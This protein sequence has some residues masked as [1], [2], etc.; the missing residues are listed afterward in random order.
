MPDRDRAG[1][2]PRERRNLQRR[3]TAVRAAAGSRGVGDEKRHERYEPGPAVANKLRGDVAIGEQQ[4]GREPQRRGRGETTY[5]RLSPR[6][7]RPPVDAAGSHPRPPT[8]GRHSQSTGVL[9]TSSRKSP[10]D[11]PGLRSRCTS[12][13]CPG[14][15]RASATAPPRVI[16][17]QRSRR[18]CSSTWR[19]A[20]A[21]E[22]VP[23][24]SR[25]RTVFQSGCSRSWC[26]SGAR[27]TRLSGAEAGSTMV[28]FAPRPDPRKR[29]ILT[30]GTCLRRLT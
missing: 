18:Q 27:T 5:W 21:L 10:F 13:A 29:T 22:H 23:R 1:H 19:G 25:L 2:Q 3:P 14:L 24:R 30:L 8:S 11:P 7:T 12:V 17:R 26:W 28:T 9:H 6:R 4:A 16:D 15:P 20:P